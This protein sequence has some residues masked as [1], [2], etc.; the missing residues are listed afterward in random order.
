MSCLQQSEEGIWLAT[1][2]SNSIPRAQLRFNC[3]D[4]IL[5]G[6]PY[7]P[8]PPWYVHLWGACSPTNCDWGEV[9]GRRLDNG[10]IYATYDHGFAR[11][12]VHIQAT[13]PGELW[14]YIYTHFVDGSG[15]QDYEMEQFMRPEPGSLHAQANAHEL[16]AFRKRRTH[17]GHFPSATSFDNNP[18]AHG[19]STALR[20][21]I[22]GRPSPPQIK[23]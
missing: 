22:R 14:V 16:V 21:V 5:N 10:V 13:S 4:Q 23:R 3:Q 12:G 8:G 17:Q 18:N 9:G 19:E 15:R 2:P 11:R 7:P 1:D 20:G 6:E